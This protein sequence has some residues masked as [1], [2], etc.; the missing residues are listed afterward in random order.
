MLKISSSVSVIIV[1]AA[2]LLFLFFIMQKRVHNLEHQVAIESAKINF[3]QSHSAEIVFDSSV[4]KG[5][6]VLYYKKGAF[7]G[8]SVTTTE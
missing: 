3:I 4:V 7:V 6:T 1:L 5:D 2:L 8:A